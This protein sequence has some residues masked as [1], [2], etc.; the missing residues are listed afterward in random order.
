MR[1]YDKIPLFSLSVS[2][3]SKSFDIPLSYIDSCEIRTDIKNIGASISFQFKDETDIMD[4]LPLK[5]GDVIDMTVADYANNEVTMKFK[6]IDVSTIQKAMDISQKNTV[7][8]RAVSENSYKMLH[9]KIYKG[10]SDKPIK[11]ILD[12]IFKGFEGITVDSPDNKIA[13]IVA[14]GQTIFSFVKRLAKLSAK[15]DNHGYLF[16]E[17]LEGIRFEPLEEII[18][19][20]NKD[21]NVYVFGEVN[22]RYRYNILDWEF[23]QRE[24]VVNTSIRQI[25][26]TK[27]VGFDVEKKAI[28]E[29]DIKYSDESIKKMGSGSTQRK[30]KTETKDMQVIYAPHHDE[31]TFKQ[32]F[33]SDILF[34]SFI[35]KIH[36][37]CNGDFN[38]NVGDIIYLNH[39]KKLDN[40]DFN[41]QL[42]GKWIVEEVVYQFHGEDFK[43]KMLLTTNATLTDEDKNEK[44]VIE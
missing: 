30:E 34:A 4:E 18:N 6:V 19:A 7:Q 17:D 23:V 29:N 36:V 43:M 40:M 20:R 39:P 15:G 32:Q 37:L 35:K 28:V 42:T 41:T 16:Y 1:F 13:S 26:N 24:D 8:V 44:G 22:E 11:G 25:N 31:Q 38:V 27:V 3:D 33:K 2:A 12:E 9:N 5:E 21:L 14:S 10:F